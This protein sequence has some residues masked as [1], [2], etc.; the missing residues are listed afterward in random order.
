MIVDDGWNSANLWE[1]GK[2]KRRVSQGTKAALT[3]RRK[4]AQGEIIVIGEELTGW[5][6]SQWNLR[7]V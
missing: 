2:R 4:R 1:K 3:G 5:W 6:S 7:S